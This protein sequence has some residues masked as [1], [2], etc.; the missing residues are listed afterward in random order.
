MQFGTVRPGLASWLLVG[1]SSDDMTF[2]PIKE[3]G[4]SPAARQAETGDGPEGGDD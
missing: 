3:E 4:V 2:V 1:Q